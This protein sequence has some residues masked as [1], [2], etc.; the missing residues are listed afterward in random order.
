MKN[1]VTQED[2][3]NILE[4]TQWTVKELHGKCTVV[5]AQLPLTLEEELL[6][7]VFLFL[8]IRYVNYGEFCKT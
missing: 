7:F 2:I 3:N 6:R 8:S 1:T 4:K 5:A